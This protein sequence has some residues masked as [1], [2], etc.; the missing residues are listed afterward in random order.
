MCCMSLYSNHGYKGEKG[1]KVKFCS[2]LV[3]LSTSGA[4]E[5]IALKPKGRD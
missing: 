1:K 5:R 3:C 4:I 2:L